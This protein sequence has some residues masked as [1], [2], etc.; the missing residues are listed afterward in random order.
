VE[1]FG[2]V[3]KRTSR[4][5][6][7]IAITGRYNAEPC[8]VG[9]TAFAGGPPGET[10]EGVVAVNE[11]TRPTGLIVTGAAGTVTGV[12]FGGCRAAGAGGAFG[13]GCDTNATTPTT[14]PSAATTATSSRFL[15]DDQRDERGILPGSPAA[16][17]AGSTTAAQPVTATEVVPIGLVGAVGT[18]AKVVECAGGTTTGFEP[19]AS[20]AA[21][22]AA[23][24]FFF[25]AAFFSVVTVFADPTVVVTVTVPGT[26]VAVGVPVELAVVVV[27]MVV[28]V[29]AVVAQLDGVIV[30]ESSVTAPFS[31]RTR[32]A[33]ETS[34][35]TVMLW[36]AKIVP[37]KLESVPSVAELPTCQNT[38]QAWAPLISTT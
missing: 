12:G 16:P 37:T 27:V 26:V 15:G 17:A 29:V 19:R 14:T 36:F 5:P 13:A 10:N 23:A 18:T 24:A 7:R 20:A 8:H 4:S 35:V 32:P 6:E 33:I 9:A 22:F 11:A 1:L 31:A 34:V 3:G 30:S 21:T 2:L 38:L 25:A 28:G